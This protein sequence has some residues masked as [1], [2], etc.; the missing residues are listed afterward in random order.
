VSQRNSTVA[1]WRLPAVEG[2]V[3]TRG[4]RADDLS[5]P[6][7]QAWER[8]FAAGR[9]AGIH[10]VRAEEQHISDALQLQLTSVSGVLDFLARPLAELDTEVEEQLMSVAICIARAV[11]RRELKTQ[12][13]AIIALVRDTVKL[14]P[15]AAREVRVHLHPDD[16]AVVRDRLA[17]PQGERAWVVLEDPV[18]SRGGCQIRSDNSTIDASVEKRLAAATAAALGDE[19]SSVG[20]GA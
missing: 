15:L 9:E 4:Q 3:V 2:P 5:S 11:V 12:P 19:R 18:L 6:D 8:G 16:A 1:T 10:A 17:Q 14:L 7:R 13:D 20:R